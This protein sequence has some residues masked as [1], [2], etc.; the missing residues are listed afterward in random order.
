MGITHLSGLEV[1]G[2]PTMGMSGLPL[3][4]GNVYFVDAVNGNDGNTGAADSPLQTVYVAYANCVD[5]NNDVVVIVGD[6]STAATQR[7]SVANAQVANP[8]A[9]AGTLVWAKDATHLVGMTAPTMFASR[10]RFAPPTGVYTAA[11]FGADVFVSV[12]AQ[13]CIFA[14]FSTFA[15]F[16][17]GSASMVAW[18]DTGGRNYYSNVQFG[19]FGDA[20][21]ADGTGAR[22]LL[23]SG[24]NGENTFDRCVIGLDTASSPRSVANANLELAGGTPRNVFNDCIFPMQAD[25]AGALSI[26]GTGNACVDRTN[27]FN[28]CKF[29]NGMSSGGTAQTVIVSFTTASPGG[30]LAM[31]QCYFIGDTN[32][33]WGDTNALAN[34]YINGASPTAGTT[35]NA[36]KPT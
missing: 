8:A 5:G 2:V 34:M 21:S 26:L 30:Q 17:T 22:A 18:S 16:S 25:N 1:A 15:G 12:T 9:T 27:Y 32:T 7:L 4:T 33:N 14:N 10:A 24:S 35:G 29:T 11:T 28:R 23:V 19:G 3:T 13:G 20:A 6:G 36:V 31:D